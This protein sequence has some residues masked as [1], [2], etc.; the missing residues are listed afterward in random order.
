MN[1]ITNFCHKL[2]ML[3][4]MLGFLVSLNGQDYNIC[5]ETNCSDGKDDDND[6]SIDCLDSDC[7]PILLDVTSNSDKCN[8]GM[9]FITVLAAGSN[10]TYSLNGTDYQELNQFDNLSPGS[11]TIFIRNEISGCIAVQHDVKVSSLCEICNN[12]IDDDGD[13]DV[14]CDDFDCLVESLQKSEAGNACF[15][16]PPEI[17]IC[18]S[19][20]DEFLSKFDASFAIW[21]CESGI[22]KIVFEFIEYHNYS[23]EAIS[24][25][26]LLKALNESDIDIDAII[27]ENEM[28]LL[29][30][31]QD[32]PRYLKWLD[33]LNYSITESE[34]IE[35][36]LSNNGYINQ[37][38][39][40]AN[41]PV[42][43]MDYYSI[44]F[45]PIMSE[46]GMQL[47]KEETFDCVRK[48]FTE[49]S[50]DCPFPLLSVI[51]QEFRLADFEGNLERWNSSDPLGTVGSFAIPG[52][53]GS[54]VLS[55]YSNSEDCLCWTFSTIEQVPAGDGTHP[56]SGNRQFGLKTDEDGRCTFFT[57][58]VD[59]AK[60][61]PIEWLVGVM[62]LRGPRPVPPGYLL[63]SLV[64]NGG[65]R[66]WACL[67]N[68]MGMLLTAK[69]SMSFSESEYLSY[70][71]NWESVVD[72]LNGEGLLECD[73]G[74]N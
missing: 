55:Q 2:L 41:G 34:K 60:V 39:G 23:D 22:E 54:V 15:P 3:F 43:N 30:C 57:R 16:E 58:G 46:D 45:D 44:S 71:P 11:F 25:V 49:A 9:G 70:R 48:L 59:R 18:I 32:D 61:R 56:V 28:F 7:L 19:E 12:G 47:S 8:T 33:L 31:A 50:V 52:N 17:S 6:G 63:S 68:N 1:R 38:I 37:P 27:S 20:Y 64:F 10:L 4:F 67:F 5:R 14:D 65:E 51:N 42:V 40:D 69:G 53:S 73:K 72:Y 74:E 62:T 35:E 36:L 26:E 13:G 66:Y 24:L 21:F 29:S